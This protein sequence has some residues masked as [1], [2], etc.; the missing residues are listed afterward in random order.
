MSVVRSCVYFKERAK[1]FA[2]GLGLETSKMV[3][4]FRLASGTGNIGFRNIGL[5]FTDM[6]RT[7]R[8]AGLRGDC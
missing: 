2:D 6:D 7:A 4:R 5:L 3:Q 8:G 1:N